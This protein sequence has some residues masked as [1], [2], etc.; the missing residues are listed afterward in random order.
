MY[1]LHTIF[2]IRGV[3]LGVCP[4]HHHTLCGSQLHL[5]IHKEGSRFCCSKK[6]IKAGVPQH[7]TN[8][9][10]F[11]QTAFHTCTGIWTHM[12]MYVKNK[13]TYIEQ[14]IKDYRAHGDM[15]HLHETTLI[16]YYM[17]WAK[18]WKLNNNNLKYNNEIY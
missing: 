5:K 3:G 10:W 11:V 17:K 1:S 15:H 13:R 7:T 4:L 12:Y 6:K 14:E 18:K 2:L 9:E 8:I 16:S